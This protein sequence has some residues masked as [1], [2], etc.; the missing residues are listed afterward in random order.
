M[1]LD[2]NN[3]VSHNKSNITLTTLQ[4]T[5]IRKKKHGRKIRTAKLSGGIEVVLGKLCLSIYTMT[6][7]T[8]CG[9]N[10]TTSTCIY[11]SVCCYYYCIR[12][13][14]FEKQS[15]HSVLELKRVN[16]LDRKGTL[17]LAHVTHTE[18]R[19]THHTE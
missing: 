1:C 13:A 19:P 7:T 16:K 2:S 9:N 10:I 6:T 8:L 15:L 4:H 5:Y 12:V 18:Y 11:S 14:T 3:H 17:A